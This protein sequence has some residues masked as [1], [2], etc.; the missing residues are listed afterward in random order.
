MCQMIYFYEYVMEE[1]YISAPIT[2]A[3]GLC[4]GVDLKAECKVILQVFERYLEGQ[5]FH[6]LFVLTVKQASAVRKQN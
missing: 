4:L 2:P 3:N 6:F 5:R 1:S